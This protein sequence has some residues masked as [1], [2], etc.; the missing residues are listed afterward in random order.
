MY[1]AQHQTL[2]ELTRLAKHSRSSKVRQRLQIII[3]AKEKKTA[4]QIASILGYAR[5]T[6]LVWV[7]R[8]NKEGLQGLE[9][10][11]AKGRQ[12]A[13]TEEEEQRLRQRLEA[14]PREEDGCCTLY[15]KDI[16]RILQE[17]FGKHL[18]LSGVYYILHSQKFSSLIPR[19]K[20]HKADQ[21]SQEE[22]K[23]KIPEQ[24]REIAQEHKH[25]EIEIWFEDEA[26]LGQQGTL[27]RVWAPK[28]SRPFAIRQ[29]EYQ[30]LHVLGAVCPKTGQAEG[31]FFSSLN[32]EIV[33]HFLEQISQSVPS[34]K[35]LV[36]LLD[37][38]GYHVSKKL[39]APHNMS[40][41]HLP[42]YSPE[43]NP[44]ENLWHYLRSHQWAN[45]YYKDVYALEEAAQKAWERVCFDADKIKT[46]CEAHYVQ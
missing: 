15:G 27:A 9:D 2:E 28:G 7:S 39:Q 43:L 8:Y 12:R 20:H 21:E 14:G 46:I 31:G 40:L 24:I 30:Y 10:R 1:V 37:R 23:K 17:E 19:P 26:R 5:S 36:I 16:Q 42:P 4:K 32:T 11:K 3:L 34:K 6:C 41:I 44:V 33:N 13:L 45:R 22:F 29:T 38:A 18:S 35:H 25:K